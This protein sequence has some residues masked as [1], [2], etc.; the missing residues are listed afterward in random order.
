MQST[1]DIKEKRRFKHPRDTFGAKMVEGAIF[2]P[3]Y[4]MPL[5]RRDSFIP[6]ALVPFSVAMQSGWNNFDCVVHF[7][8][9]DQDIE[10]FW[11]YPNRYLPKLQKFQGVIGPDFSTCVDFPL[12]LKQ[13]NAY[14]N[15]AGTYKLQSVGLLAMP[16]LRGDPEIFEWEIAGLEKGC[17]FAVSPRGC[18]RE[19]DNRKRFERGL[20]NLVDAL[21]PTFIISYGRN[22]FGVLDYPLEQGISVYQYASRGRGDLGGGAY[23]EQIS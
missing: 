17:A 16:L 18:V 21:E 1:T 9:R 3:K 13:W 11:S 12:A 23:S 8:E 2:D 22:S 7:C 10:P 14:R 20:K 6:N 5:L 4:D 19:L 15:R